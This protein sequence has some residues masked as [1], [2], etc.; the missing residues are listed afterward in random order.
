MTGWPP[1]VLQS[2]SPSRR[3]TEAEPEA[4]SEREAPI[5]F[6]WPTRS[7]RPSA[8]AAARRRRPAKSAN[9]QKMD[10]LKRNQELNNP[11]EGSQ[12]LIHFWDLTQIRQ[13]TQSDPIILILYVDSK[14][15]QNGLLKAS[16]PPP[17]GCCLVPTS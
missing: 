4:T 9:V 13:L 14:I 8:A 16:R 10:R 15:N 6:P 1:T 11:A 12:F 17:C 5:T 2:D 3:A 7:Q